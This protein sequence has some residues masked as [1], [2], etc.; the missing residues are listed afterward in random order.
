MDT[1]EELFPPTLDDMIQC[2]EREIRYREHV[3]PRRIAAG[4]MAQRTADREIRV[5][6]AILARLQAERLG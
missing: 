5:M 1:T 6:R 4:K 2:A 3:Y